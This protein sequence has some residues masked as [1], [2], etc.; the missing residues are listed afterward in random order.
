MPYVDNEG[1]FPLYK[2]QVQ[3]VIPDWDYGNDLPEGWAEI[4]ILDK[5]EVP[6]GKAAFLTE[7]IVW[8]EDVPTMG[9]VILD[10]PPVFV[11][12]DLT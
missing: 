2:P 7:E 4:V 11:E 1:N 10:A 9:W 3:E 6:E 8:A 5:P 12:E